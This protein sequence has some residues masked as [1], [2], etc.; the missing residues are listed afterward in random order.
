VPPNGEIL[1][2]ELKRRLLFQAAF[3]VLSSAHAGLGYV[4]IGCV[5]GL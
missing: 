3:L 5:Y 4:G 1:S 2:D